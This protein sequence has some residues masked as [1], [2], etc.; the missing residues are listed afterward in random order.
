MIHGMET[1]CNN[2]NLLMKTILFYLFKM[3]NYLL[4]PLLV[5]KSL[6]LPVCDT[7][8]ISYIVNS[9]FPATFASNF[10]EQQTWH[11]LLDY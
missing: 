8:H 2:N 1:Y 5:F 3:F 9:I 11:F 7:I 4:Y 10:Q 6:Y